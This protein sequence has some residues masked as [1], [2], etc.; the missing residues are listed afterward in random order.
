MKLVFLRCVVYHNQ[1]IIFCRYVHY[2]QF[3]FYFGISLFTARRDVVAI[4]QFTCSVSTLV[5]WFLRCYIGDMLA[6]F[7]EQEMRPPVKFRRHANRTRGVRCLVRKGKGEVEPLK[8]EGLLITVKG[9]FWNG[10]PL[11]AGIGVV[12][13]AITLKCLMPVC[14]CSAAMVMLFDIKTPVMKWKVG[15]QFNPFIL[16][17]Y[18]KQGWVN[19]QAMSCSLLPCGAHCPGPARWGL[20]PGGAHWESAAYRWVFWVILQVFW[21]K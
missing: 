1:F 11:W 20:L 8:S 15:F 19:H 3:F 9:S 12:Y 2:I 4:H 7:D 14:A 13:P 17:N 6:H 16:W 21:S 18:R 5:L 10:V